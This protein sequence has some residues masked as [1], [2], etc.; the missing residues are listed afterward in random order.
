MASSFAPV[1]KSTHAL[2]AEHDV[3]WCGISLW[4]AGASCP[5]CPPSQLLVHPQTLT[6]GVSGRKG[7]GSVQA[8]LSND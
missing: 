4:S 8:L 2:C 5:G 7:L 6:G 1:L 3:L